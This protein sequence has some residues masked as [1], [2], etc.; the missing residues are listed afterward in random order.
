MSHTVSVSGP[1]TGLPPVRKNGILKVLLKT[2]GKVFRSGIHI[3]QH[4]DEAVVETVEVRLRQCLLAGFL[5]LL[6]GFLALDNLLE[7]VPCVLVQLAPESACFITESHQLLIREVEEPR[8]ATVPYAVFI[9]VAAQHLPGLLPGG[10][11]NI[12]ALVGTV[13]GA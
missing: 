2:V 11:G 1:C 6:P 4:G 10:P 13:R 8:H 7:V 3:G 5:H 9:E 12:L